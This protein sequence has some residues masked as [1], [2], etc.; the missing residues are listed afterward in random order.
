MN[1]RP[2]HRYW[3]ASS[4]GVHPVDELAIFPVALPPGA[5]GGG[6][7]THPMLL[8][9]DP[10]ALVGSPIWPS[11]SAF[12]F[13]FAAAELALK[14]TPIR[15]PHCA[16]TMHL[17]LY[18]IPVVL[19]PI[20]PNITTFAVHVIVDKATLVHAALAPHELP[21]AMLPAI[22]EGTCE[23]RAIAPPLDAL[24]IL[25][26]LQPVALVSGGLRQGPNAVTDQPAL[27]FLHILLVLAFVHSAISICVLCDSMLLAIFELA[28]VS[29]PIKHRQRA[30]SV[31]DTVSTLPNVH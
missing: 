26:I 6:H 17:V 8:S 30:L 2:A 4:V 16:G 28:F 21:M 19:P 7:H 31:E 12:A 10:L 15:P 5:L 18:P 24:T 20:R 14:N 13:L 22:F 27:A 1:A 29:S 25:Q 23:D 9:V 11:E 3:L